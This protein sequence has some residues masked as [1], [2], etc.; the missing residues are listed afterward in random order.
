M[1]N[2]RPHDQPSEVFQS[3]YT[4]SC[5]HRAF[6]TACIH[7]SRC[8]VKNPMPGASDALPIA[9]TDDVVVSVKLVIA[10]RLCI[11]QPPVV[12]QLTQDQLNLQVVNPH[13]SHVAL[14][15]ALGCRAALAAMIDALIAWIHGPRQK[16]RRVGVAARVDATA[17]AGAAADGIE[18]HNLATAT[19]Q[20]GQRSLPHGA[21]CAAVARMVCP[22]ALVCIVGYAICGWCAT[23][24]SVNQRAHSIQGWHRR[25]R[26]GAAWPARKN[27]HAA[28]EWRSER[29]WYT[30]GA[31]WHS[32][33]GV[34]PHAKIYMAKSSAGCSVKCG[35]SDIVSV[36]PPHGRTE[37]CI[38]NSQD[39]H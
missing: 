29:V 4:T 16:Q 20:A 8:T 19:R 27:I 39:D 5:C 23:N 32:M 22:E 33:A 1:S 36:V 18:K 37:M 13:V 25:G 17:K 10:H 11:S 7:L 3:S 15:A 26:Y 31:V 28:Q 6:A 2:Q 35:T 9:L 21:V 30:C 14:Q 24:T 38:Q 34:G 12:S